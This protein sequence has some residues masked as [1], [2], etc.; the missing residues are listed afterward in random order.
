M[1]LNPPDLQVSFPEWQERPRPACVRESVRGLWS[2]HTEQKTGEY[3]TRGGGDRE[4]QAKYTHVHSPECETKSH[5]C[6]S[7]AGVLLGQRKE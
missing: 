4:H 6:P 3:S 2:R 7:H 5:P 1:I